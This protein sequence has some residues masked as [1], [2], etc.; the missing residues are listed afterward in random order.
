MST[1]PPTLPYQSQVPGQRP[2]RSGSGWMWVAG[3]ACGFLISGIAWPATIVT[4]TSVSN[5]AALLLIIPIV[6]IGTKIALGLIIDRRLA[7]SG[8]LPG[9]LL[10]IL[11]IPLIGFGTL[12]AVCFGSSFTLN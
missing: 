9:V 5:S 7:R 10:S 3:I 2:P 11:L 4:F 6:A 8:F 12:A 1:Q